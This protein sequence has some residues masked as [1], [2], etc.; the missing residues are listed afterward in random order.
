MMFLFVLT[1]ILV[2]NIIIIHFKFKLNII[3]KIKK[4]MTKSM[5]EKL[6]FAFK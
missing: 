2:C 5:I 1:F 3:I 4:N 6:I